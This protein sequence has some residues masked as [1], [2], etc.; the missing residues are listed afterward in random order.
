MHEP[1]VVS[2]GI[3]SYAIVTLPKQEIIRVTVGDGANRPDGYRLHYGTARHRCEYRDWTCSA[4]ICIRSF[5]I[6]AIS[7]WR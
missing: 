3:L 4:W 5:G 6:I 1:A 7:T 2:A